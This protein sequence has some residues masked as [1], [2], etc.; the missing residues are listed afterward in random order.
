[1]WLFWSTGVV[2]IKLLS[3]LSSDWASHFPHTQQVATYIKYLKVPFHALSEL[4]AFPLFQCYWI[5]RIHFP[6]LKDEG[7][8]DTQ[9]G[10][11]CQD[12]QRLVWFQIPNGG[13][14]FVVDVL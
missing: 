3:Q 7:F 6:M 14:A 4:S 12:P 10:Y 11:R 1:M 9:Q 5:Q 8:P 13:D 2:P